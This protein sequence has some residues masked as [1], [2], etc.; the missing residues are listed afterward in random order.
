MNWREK[1]SSNTSR[2]PEI[3]ISAAILRALTTRWRANSASRWH[4]TSICARGPFDS[5][6]SDVDFPTAMRLL[7]DMTGTFWRPL[8]PRLFFVSQDT[9]QKR[10]DYQPS[11]VRSI[12]LPASETPEQMTETLRLVRDITGITRSNLDTSSRTITL[13]ASP[14]AV[15][16]A[17]DL[18]DDLQKPTGGL[19]LEMEVLEVDRNAA[20][21]LGITPPQTSQILSLNTQEI[22]EAQQS[23]QGLVSV[24]TQLFGQPS[25]L[26]GL[27][28]SQI[29]SLLGSG[30]VGLGSLIPPVVALG[31]GESTF[32]ATVPGAAANFSEMLSLVQHGRRILLRAQDGQAGH[33]LRG[34]SRPGGAFEFFREPVGDG[35]E[36]RR[37]SHF[38][39]P[40]DELR[41]RQ[42]SHLRIARRASATIA[43]TT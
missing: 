30:Q 24:I 13:R 9:P 31:G 4:S 33:V 25:S 21:Q 3:S 35:D 29:T 37:R 41:H 32:L 6:L 23:V 1:S 22:Q 10:R 28:T 36:R 34:R 38:E 20:R 12:L 18:I 19:I 2:E 5:K 40:D 43:M 16:V 39:F 17:S 15:A 42:R 26:S 7:G 11:V 8:A 14:Q 27:S